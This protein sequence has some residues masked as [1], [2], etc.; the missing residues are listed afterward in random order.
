MTFRP[1]KHHITQWELEEIIK[2]EE[3]PHPN[4]LQVVAP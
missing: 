2:A 3:D 1:I 4:Y